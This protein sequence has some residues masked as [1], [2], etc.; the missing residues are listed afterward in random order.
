MV[1]R[2]Q[3]REI[4]DAAIG[5]AAKT[6]RGLSDA[7]QSGLDRWLEG[8]SRRLGAFVRAQAAW[9]HSERAVALGSEADRLETWDKEQGAPA[10]P[11][12]RRLDR[13]LLITGGGA[14]A[15]S[16]AGGLFVLDRPRTVESG[17][18]ETRRLTLAGGSTLTLDTATRVRIAQGSGDRLLELV[19]GK[20]FLN[21]LSA[22]RPLTLSIGGLAMRMAWGAFGLESLGEAPITAFVTNGQLAVSQ[23]RG[24]WGRPRALTLSANRTITLPLGADLGKADVRAMNADDVDKLLAWRD[25][26]LSFGDETLATAVRAFDRYGPIRIMVADPRLAQQKITGLFKANDPTGFATA[27]ASSFGAAVSRDGDVLRIFMKK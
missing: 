14:L 7:E 3:A 17:V 27:I 4:D 19:H 25:G 22:N 23:G 9:I 13:R 11:G 10:P 20:V 6:A 8:D 1:N 16:I 5:W 15:A 26:M 18:G 21:I 12:Q 24:L 2:E